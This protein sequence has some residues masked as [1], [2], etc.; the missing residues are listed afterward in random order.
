MFLILI[1]TNMATN[2]LC[3]PI[4]FVDE[5]S[6]IW[7]SIT[8]LTVVFCVCVCRRQRVFI[9]TWWNAS[10]RRKLYIW[11]TAPSCYDSVRATLQ[12]PSY[13]GRCRACPIKNVSTSYM[14]FIHS[15][16]LGVNWFMI[17]NLKSDLNDIQTLQA[18]CHALFSSLPFQMWTWSPNLPGWSFSTG[19]LREPNPCLKRS[20]APTPN[21]Q[22]CGPSS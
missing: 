14:S 15:L 7:N 12:M 4:C 21:A 16:K 17:M 20:W 11:V 22:I 6:Q 3:I 9:K 10:D 2:I 13:R 19:I 18:A 5:S 1:D 8:V